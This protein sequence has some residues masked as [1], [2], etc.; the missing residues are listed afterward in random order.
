MTPHR[1][2]NLLKRNPLIDLRSSTQVVGQNMPMYKGP[3]QVGDIAEL[4]IPDEQRDEQR[5]EVVVES[6]SANT[7]IGKITVLPE[8][9]NES[10]EFMGM[11]EG[12]PIE[13]DESE[14]HDFRLGR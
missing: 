11:K 4:R 8:T 6:I 7:F 12:E 9:D 5:I 2:K 1:P 14:I 13:F 3:I 10:D